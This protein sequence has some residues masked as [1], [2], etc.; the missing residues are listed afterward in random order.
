MT[1]FVFVA[2]GVA[3]VVVVFATAGV[4]AVVIAGSAGPTALA[5]SAGCSAVAAYGDA[6]SASPFWPYFALRL[7]VSV[8]SGAP[9]STTFV[10][11]AG[12]CATT[13]FAA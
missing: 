13:V 7:R 9:V 8:T 2:V 3:A 5:S 1:D 11:G 6:S 12:D 4:F 10:P